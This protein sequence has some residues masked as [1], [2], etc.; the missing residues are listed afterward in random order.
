MKNHLIFIYMI[1]PSKITLKKNKK[2]LIKFINS[3][4]D[5]IYCFK[6]K[7]GAVRGEYPADLVNL[8]KQYYLK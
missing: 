8:N 4:V 2:C 3:L 7:K 5:R 1:N 6:S